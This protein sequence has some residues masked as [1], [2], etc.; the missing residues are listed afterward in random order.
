MNNET[1][2]NHLVLSPFREV[3]VKCREAVENAKTAQN[4]AGVQAMTKASRGLLTKSERA[5]GKIE[6]L[7]K[8]L[9]EEYGEVFI[10]ALKESGMFSPSSSS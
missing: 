9:L 6:P 3:V 4:D 1:Q 2:L 8:R 7:C 5:L 10:D